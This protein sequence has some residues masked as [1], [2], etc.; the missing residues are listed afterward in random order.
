MVAWSLQGTSGHEGVECIWEC[1]PPCYHS[2]SSGQQDGERLQGRAPSSHTDVTGGHTCHRCRGRVGGQGRAQR[3]WFVRKTCHS[4]AKMYSVTEIY[5][6]YGIYIPGWRGEGAGCE[7]RRD[8]LDTSCLQKNSPRNDKPRASD[9]WY[10]G[11]RQPE[12]LPCGGARRETIHGTIATQ[13]VWP[14]ECESMV[15][16]QGNIALTETARLTTFAFCSPETYPLSWGVSSSTRGDKYSVLGSVTD[17]E[18][19]SNPTF[20]RVR[21]LTIRPPSRLTETYST[22]KAEG[23]S[24]KGAARLGGRRTGVGIKRSGKR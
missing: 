8:N 14:V 24:S 4:I 9:T 6:I 1:R 15:T 21:F 10:T 19:A 16:W 18:D 11:D 12:E 3:G 2:N 23:Y 5:K 17:G 22:E 7:T 20:S 13:R